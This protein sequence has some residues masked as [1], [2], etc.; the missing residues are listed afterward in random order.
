MIRSDETPKCKPAD[1][2][3]METGG[4]LSLAPKFEQLVRA[5]YAKHS[6]CS[7]YVHLTDTVKNTE[8][9]INTTS[10]DLSV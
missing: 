4:C 2:D 10:A 3:A 7:H 1:H 5:A 8:S 9:L 6:H